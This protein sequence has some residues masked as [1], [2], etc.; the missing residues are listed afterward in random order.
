V[1]QWNLSAWNSQLLQVLNQALRL[2]AY[3]EDAWQA[4]A[5]Y[6][7]LNGRAAFLAPSMMMGTSGVVNQPGAESQCNI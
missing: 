1:R 3:V 2:L 6:P 4:T 5:A 7:R